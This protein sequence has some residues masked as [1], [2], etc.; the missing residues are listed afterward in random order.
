[1]ENKEEIVVEFWRM[2]LA[3]LIKDS[4]FEIDHV[5]N[6]GLVKITKERIIKG[7]K[8]ISE[9]EKLA[10]KFDIP[11]DEEWIEKNN[12][13]VIRPEIPISFI[14]ATQKFKKQLENIVSDEIENQL[15]WWVWEVGSGPEPLPPEILEWLIVGLELSDSEPI[16]T[17]V[18]DT[19]EKQDIL[20]TL[21]GECPNHTEN[22]INRIVGIR[23]TSSSRRGK[24]KEIKRDF[25][26]SL[27]NI[28]L[29]RKNSDYKNSF[30]KS[31][32]RNEDRI[33]KLVLEI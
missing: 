23:G 3:D 28:G 27:F 8:F 14:R 4:D 1:M 26:R 19:I 5:A 10:Y 21:I 11:M 22:L 6:K 13:G 33:H 24:I 20:K 32:E 29:D 9:I 15:D 18:L 31:V 2:H 17:G 7:K 12:S 16:A 25:K 30:K